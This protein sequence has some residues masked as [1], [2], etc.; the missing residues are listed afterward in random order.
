MTEEQ[1]LD[2][3]VFWRQIARMPDLQALIERAGRRLAAR[4]GEEYDPKRHAGYPQIT[5]DEWGKWDTA[6]AEFQEW[7]RRSI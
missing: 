3:A 1:H 7:H 2:D 6:N 5:P 4:L